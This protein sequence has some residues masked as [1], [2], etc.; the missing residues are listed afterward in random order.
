MKF[1]FEAGQYRK[2][3]ADK[4]REKRADDRNEAK[5]LLEKERE[6][7]KYHVAED[8]KKVLMNIEK[9]KKVLNDNVSP[10]QEKQGTD[11]ERESVEIVRMEGSDGIEHV[12]EIR[13]TDIS[14]RIPEEVKLIYD[15]YR[16]AVLDRKLQHSNVGSGTFNRFRKEEGGYYTVLDNIVDS[17]S[18][19]DL[20]FSYLLTMLNE[21]DIQTFISDLPPGGLSIAEQIREREIYDK[22][23]ETSHE[24]G[25]VVYDKLHNFLEIIT[26]GAI[27]DKNVFAHVVGAEEE[28]FNGFSLKV[29]APEK[30]A[31]LKNRYPHKH[32]NDVVREQEFDT[33]GAQSDYLWVNAGGT[34]YDGLFKPTMLCDSRNERFR[35]EIET[36]SLYSENSHKRFNQYLGEI[37]SNR[38]SD[39]IINPMDEKIQAALMLANERTIAGIRIDFKREEPWLFIADQI[40][41]LY[42][43]RLYKITEKVNGEMA[44]VRS[45]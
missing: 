3:L 41:D 11:T 21:E 18:T 1:S 9:K 44:E 6:T 30:Y 10:E 16:L 17:K 35:K 19:H 14:D 29:S 34:F 26:N 24:I 36:F 15:I 23:E 22:T 7:L 42:H 37:R 33:H 13:T 43:G 27:S 8:I 38:Q 4:V 12:L 25:R 2:N 28:G 32:Q 31:N 20:L 45:V 39:E 5:E 40:V